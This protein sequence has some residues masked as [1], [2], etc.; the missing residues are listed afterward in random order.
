[1]KELDEFIEEYTNATAFYETCHR[2][3]EEDV[4]TIDLNLSVPGSYPRGLVYYVELGLHK[5]DKF[6]LMVDCV[7]THPVIAMQ[8][9]TRQ[10]IDV[11]FA[12][13]DINMKLGELSLYLDEGIGGK[14]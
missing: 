7:P 10:L 4:T 9:M 14:P 11:S 2:P 8:I 6:A 5:D 13:I 12:L 3:H 1:M